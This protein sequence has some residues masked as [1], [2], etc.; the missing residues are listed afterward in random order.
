V[1]GRVPQ[2]VVEQ[3]A[4]NVDF[5][6]IVGR[7]CDVKQRGNRYW[8]LCP[9]HEEK[10]PSFSIDPDNGLYYCFGC[11]EG[12]N[13][14]TFLQ[15]MEGLTFGE[16]LKT[17][18]A[19]AGIDLSQYSG[20]NGASTGRATKLREIHELA[21]AFYQKCLSKSSGG[22]KARDYLT[23]RNFTPESV[24]RWRLG[25]APDGWEHF[26]N[27]ATGRGYPA[28]LVAEAGLAVPRKNSPGHYD[29]F[30]NRLMFPIADAA[31]RTI[32][33][34]GRALEADQDT[35][36][37]NSPET[38]L[39]NKGSSFFGLAQAKAAIRSGGTAVVLEGYTDVIMSHQE[40]VEQAIAVLGTALTE[41]HGRRLSRLCDRV[42]LVFDP[43]EAGQKST[44]RSIEVL[45]N[46]DMEIRVARLPTGLDPCDFIVERGG[47]AFRR[48][49]EESIGFFEFRL[50][51]ARRENDQTSI[52]GR[53][54]AFR[55]VGEF[56]ARVKDPTQ[57]DMIVRWIADELNV[58][59]RSVWSFV[60]SRADS[61]RPRR[62]PE[63]KPEA[64]KVS[65]HDA[66]PGEL[67]GVLL[68]RPELIAEVAGRVPLRVMKECA[69]TEVVRR[70]VQQVDAD[71]MPSIGSF[72]NS[73]EQQQ[74]ASAASA[75]LAEEKVRQARVSD[76]EGNVRARLNGYLAYLQRRK[77]KT[78]AAITPPEDLDDRALLE[79]AERLKQQDRES[80]NQR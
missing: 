27:C 28:E 73:L 3:I 33:F 64:R 43:D 1:A 13:V 26:L 48:L 12:G 23:K 52:E 16:A 53:T 75:A 6:R 51:L 60:E 37:L 63:G 45:L 77:E 49:V 72:V 35:K 74:L 70:L 18:A 66:V 58:N 5:V 30:R 78:M 42:V 67:L 17:L 62:A 39:F 8:A 76:P 59:P 34:G 56:A 20:A 32:A 71:G 25:Y 69:E 2:H 46:E 31:G 29:R 80:A 19:E 79:R 55:Q 10:T 57:R 65:A 47:D 36:Y 14:F 61:G 38:P 44:A 40:G 24:E 7:Y 11:K 21:T 54:A 41:Q 68:S 9:F 4:R 50:E 15:K 22:E